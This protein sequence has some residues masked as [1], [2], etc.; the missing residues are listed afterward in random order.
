MKAFV[1]G[2]AYLKTN[3][4]A[5]L[6]SISKFTKLS[7]RTVLEEAYNTYALRL[8]PRVP[9]PSSKGIDAIL[10]DLGKKNPKARTA[11]S[12]KFIDTSFLK[13][14]ET[15]GFVAQLYRK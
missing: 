6:R 5:S 15:S 12:A 3:K 2:I 8:L 7:D 4:E 13:E 1:E 10:E 11:D 14:L 9:Y